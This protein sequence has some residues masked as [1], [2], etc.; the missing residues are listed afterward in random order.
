MLIAYYQGLLTEARIQND[1][2]PLTE[3]I[4]GMFELIGVKATQLASA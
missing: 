4:R 3:A 1:L 2:A